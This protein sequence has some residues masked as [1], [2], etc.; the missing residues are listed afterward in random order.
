M[1]ASVSVYLTKKEPDR[2]AGVSAC[3]LIQLSVS[4]RTD[5]PPMNRGYSTTPPADTATCISVGRSV[6][7]SPASVLPASSGCHRSVRLSR[8]CSAQGAAFRKCRVIRAASQSPSQV[9]IHSPPPQPQEPKSAVFLCVRT[10]AAASHI[11]W[12]SVSSSCSAPIA[13]Q[14]SATP[15]YSSAFAGVNWDGPR[16]RLRHSCGISG[17]APIDHCNLTHTVFLLTSD[18]F[19]WPVLNHCRLSN[20]L[21]FLGP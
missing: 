19:F 12:N 17:S 2:Q 16:D 4:I 7:P 6:R 8:E 10:G 13:G 21:S 15:S 18:R 3:H 9:C 5:H 14:P 11:G 20:G 1:A